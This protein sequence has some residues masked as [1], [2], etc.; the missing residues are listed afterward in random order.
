MNKKEKNLLS[1]FI[2]L[3]LFFGTALCSKYLQSLLLGIGEDILGRAFNNPGFWISLMTRIGFFFIISSL[4]SIWLLIREHKKYQTLYS[5][6]KDKINYSLPLCIPI[7]VFLFFVI[8]F[9]IFGKNSVI[10]IHDN[11]DG[12]AAFFHY[13]HQ[14]KLFWAFDKEVPLFGGTSTLFINREGFYLYNFIYCLLPTYVGY[15]V[16]HIVCIVLGFFCM[17]FLQKLIFKQ[18]NII[19]I[20]LTSLAYAV[21]PSV[22]VYKMAVAT[23]PFVPILF[24]KLMTTKEKRWII[25]SLVYPFL[26]EFSSVG[27]FICGF[28]FMAMIIICIKKKELNKRLLFGFILICVGF[29]ICISR[30]IYMRFILQETLNRDFET[31]NP[32]PFIH[33]LITYFFSGY[34]HSATLQ[35]RLIDWVILG[36]SIII[37]IKTLKNKKMQ[38][39]YLAVVLFSCLLTMLF[40]SIIAALSEAKIM[41]KIVNVVFPPLKGVSFTRIYMISRVTCYVAFTASLLYIANKEEHKGIAYS[42]AILQLVIIFL[43]NTFYSDSELTW[44]KNIV[45]SNDIS[46]TNISWKEFFSE[47][48]FSKIKDSINYSGEPVCAV[49]YHPSVLLYNDFNTIDGYLSVYPRRQQLLWHN[50][51][52]PEFERNEQDKNYFDSWGGRRYV[53]NKDLSWEPTREKYHDAVDLYINMDILKKDFGCKYIL[54]RAE[55]SN[56]VELGL[57]NVGTFDSADSIYCI[58]VYE[59][60]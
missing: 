19:I 32:I 56:A 50:L 33:S 59:V 5:I 28:W 17:F 26:S 54:S 4:I 43:S 10:T 46:W 18:E 24:F 23:L 47:K 11:L 44:K 16:N 48:Q 36:V 30:L 35:N 52:E 58:W 1:V 12:S 37:I 27:L 3:F 60:E 55:L 9:V 15:V 34:Y 42:F 21:L 6:H 53:Y 49:G 57:K 41:D 2:V 29:L 38:Y 31:V 14:H 13:I 45:S 40:C 20:I 8:P 25:I 51:M 7:I 22:A 39:S